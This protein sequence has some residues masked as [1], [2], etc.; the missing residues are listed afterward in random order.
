ML[1][2]GCPTALA[3]EPFAPVGDRE[4]PGICLQNDI[5]K[6][7]GKRGWAGVERPEL[8]LNYIFCYYKYVITD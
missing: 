8:G 1:I 7:G 4:Q 5:T 3:V 6:K 2:K